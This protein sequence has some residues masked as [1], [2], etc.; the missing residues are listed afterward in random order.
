[1]GSRGDDEFQWKYDG[2]QSRVNAFEYSRGKGR[3]ASLTPTSQRSLAG[4]ENAPLFQSAFQDADEL[5]E[6]YVL[7]GH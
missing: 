6:K 5:L 2:L 4:F 7:N 3:D 1:M